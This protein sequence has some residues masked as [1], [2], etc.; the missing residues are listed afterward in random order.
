[1]RKP[2]FKYS[3]TLFNL[4]ELKNMLK[5]VEWA[6]FPYRYV[7]DHTEYSILGEKEFFL[8]KCLF[9]HNFYDKLSYKTSKYG[10]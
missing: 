8:E 2:L 9:S 1:M 3:L 5:K 6:N 7:P 4:I 10:R